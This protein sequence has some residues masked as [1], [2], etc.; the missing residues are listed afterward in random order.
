MVAGEGSAG[1]GQTRLDFIGN[2]QN[3]LGT[4]DFAHR[5]QVVV[6][7]RDDAGL[8][9]DRLQQH[10]DGVL[11]DRVGQRIGVGDAAV[12]RVAPKNNFVGVGIFAGTSDSAKLA[13]GLYVGKADGT[14]LTAGFGYITP[15]DATGPEMV[16]IATT[17][18]IASNIIVVSFS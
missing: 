10:S 7:W 4:A 1:A 12:A 14:M 17:A 8:A 2:Q 3:V 18:A 16:G 5:R 15:G 6:R 11:V 13:Q 9:L